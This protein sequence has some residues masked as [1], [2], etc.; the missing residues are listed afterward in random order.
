MSPGS[1]TYDAQDDRASCDCGGTVTT[2]GADAALQQY[3]CGLCG[4][5]A[6]FER[7]NDKYADLPPSEG[8]LPQS[9]LTPSILEDLKR[10]ERQRRSEQK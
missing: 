3:R 7:S 5:S 2:E 9:R 6:Q 8:K 10:A 1:I 4:S